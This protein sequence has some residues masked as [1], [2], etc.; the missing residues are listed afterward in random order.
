MKEYE[1][2]KIH[3]EEIYEYLKQ[4]KCMDV[5]GRIRCWKKQIWTG[6]TT[7]GHTSLDFNKCKCKRRLL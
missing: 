3:D 7:L 4:E 5:K 1:L 2:H 6:L